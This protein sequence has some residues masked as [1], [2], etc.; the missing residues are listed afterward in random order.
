MFLSFSIT[1]SFPSI[2]LSYLIPFAITPSFCINF[3]FFPLFFLLSF[4]HSF[5]PFLYPICLLPLPYFLSWLCL[6]ATH[7]FPHFCLA[8][9]WL[10]TGHTEPLIALDEVRATSS[11][12]PY[13]PPRTA[14]WRCLC[15]IF[16]QITPLAVDNNTWFTGWKSQGSVKD[17][18]GQL[19]IQTEC[20]VLF[21]GRDGWY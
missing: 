13:I 2:S 7:D 12:A 15:R 4:P 16:Y 20:R 19:N 21:T 6:S 5:F 8:S 3:F 18:Q 1:T 9:W 14:A 11:T 10:W 17:K